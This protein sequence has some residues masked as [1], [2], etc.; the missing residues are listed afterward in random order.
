MPP[1]PIDDYSTQLPVPQQPPAP[2]EDRS[3]PAAPMDPQSQMMMQLIGQMLQRATAQTARPQ[4]PIQSQP[5]TLQFPQTM[6]MAGR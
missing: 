1:A 5:Q 2:I 3:T 6:G 4:L